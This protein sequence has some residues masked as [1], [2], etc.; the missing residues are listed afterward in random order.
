MRL[1]KSSLTRRKASVK[2]IAAINRSKIRDIERLGKNS[3]SHSFPEE[4]QPYA[5][6]GLLLGETGHP[7][8][9][10]GG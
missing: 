5:A 7:A 6:T 1:K 10:D 8:R 3:D 4:R 2:R 9:R